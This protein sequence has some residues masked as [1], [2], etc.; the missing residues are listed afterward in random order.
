MILII[1]IILV[2]SVALKCFG[3]LTGETEDLKHETQQTVNDN[4]CTSRCKYLL[5]N[6]KSNKLQLI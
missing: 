3:Y 4:K 5:E 6:N 2:G 1:M